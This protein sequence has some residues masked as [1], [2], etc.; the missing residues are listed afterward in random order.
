MN[1]TVLARLI[2]EQEV[3]DS[4]QLRRYVVVAEKKSVAE[5][6]LRVLRRLGA[7]ALITSVSGHL[8][9]CD[10]MERFSKWRLEDIPEMFSPQNVRLVTSDER[11]YRR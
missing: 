1:V 10:L 6:L 3:C 7:N 11:S 2:A 8:M 5:A 4:D 9:D